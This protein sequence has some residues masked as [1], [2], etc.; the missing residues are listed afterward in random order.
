MSQFIAIEGNIGAG[1]TTLAK[2]L[3]ERLD[4]RLLLEDFAENPFLAAFYDNRERY[5]FS[6]EMSFLADRYHQLKSLMKEDLFQPRI[7]SD[8]SLYK[9]LIF[10]QNNLK[11]NELSLYRNLFDIMAGNLKQ[12]DLVIFLNRSYETLRKHIRQRGRSYEQGIELEYLMNI[13][14]NYSRFFKQK[15]DVPVLVLEADN[16]DFLNRPSDVEALE[17]VLSRELRE[18][19]N[20][21]S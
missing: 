7:I 1:K 5:A 17:Q 9:S 8:Y 10:A 12:P 19:L 2:I 11:D 13:Q 14:E 4:A 6:L 18:G 16:Y 21:I 15:H 20:F 3:S